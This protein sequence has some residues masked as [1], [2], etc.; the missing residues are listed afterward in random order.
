M[1]TSNVQTARK[2]IDAVAEQQ[3]AP[4]AARLLAALRDLAPE[5][6]AR[7]REIEDGRRV[8][9]DIAVKLR[10]LG[11][12]TE[13]RREHASLYNRL[14]RDSDVKT[15]AVA[16]DVLEFWPVVLVLPLLL[17]PHATS[18][19]PANTSTATARQPCIRALTLRDNANCM[20]RPSLQIEEVVGSTAVTAAG[21]QAVAFARPSPPSDCGAAAPS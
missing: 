8:P 19:R 7:S 4:E 12:W 15:P 9:S 17:L 16:P 3:P 10:R 13:A 21:V 20:P 18:N 1:A 2:R 5:F 6:A 11:D 14:L